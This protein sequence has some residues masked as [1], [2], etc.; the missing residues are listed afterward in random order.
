MSII[1]RSIGTYFGPLFLAKESLIGHADNP[2]GISVARRSIEPRSSEA[3]A[4][5]P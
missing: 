2:D 5:K 1:H 3:Q 4:K